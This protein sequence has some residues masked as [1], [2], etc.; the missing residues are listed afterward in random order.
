MKF[1]S[2]LKVYACVIECNAMPANFSG[3][4]YNV[5][6]K[7][8]YFENGLIHNEKGPAV[9]DSNGTVEWWINDKRH[10]INGPAIEYVNGSK[11]WYF[12]GKLHR[13]DGP[14]IEHTNGSKEWYKNNKLHRLGGPAVEW[15]NGKKFWYIEGTLYHREE[16]YLRIIKEMNESL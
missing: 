10:K 13:E 15:N 12:E 4:I 3:I 7:I 6:R 8:Y 2:L 1:N 14:A 16:Y 9:I 5:Y 11:L